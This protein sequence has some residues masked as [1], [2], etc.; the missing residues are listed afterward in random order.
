MELKHEPD[1]RHANREVAHR[2]IGRMA[3]DTF[4]GM[5]ISNLIAFFIILTA[6]VTLYR[7]GVTD[8]ATS[9]QAA[10]AL[11]PIAGQF[12]FLLFG[13]GIIGTGFL[14][15]PVLAGSAAYAMAE[16]FG[17][18]RGLEKKPAEAKT[19]Y[20]VMVAAM[21]MATAAIFMPVDPIRMLFWT[22]V[23][24]GVISVPILAAMMVL[25]RRHRQMGAY[26]A[27]AWQYGLGWAATLVMALAVAAMFIFD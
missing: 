21:V 3:V 17:L 8:I 24:N 9:A 4:T 26:V 1:L 12:A 13:A 11:R 10:E 18:P 15:M 22:A 14:A 6:A 27:H 2:E 16:A 25:S 7:A 23:I 20:G 5:A 19:F